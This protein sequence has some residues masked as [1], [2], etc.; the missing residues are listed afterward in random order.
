MVELAFPLLDYVRL[1]HRRLLGARQIL[2]HRDERPEDYQP[3]SPLVT[4]SCGE[5]GE[6]TARIPGPG[7]GIID[8]PVCGVVAQYDDP[9]TG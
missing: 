6:R 3:S 8:C 2:Q 1:E 7:G 9:P 4:G 5:C